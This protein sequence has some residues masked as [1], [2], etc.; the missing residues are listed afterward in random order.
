MNSIKTKKIIVV[1]WQIK[2]NSRIQKIVLVLIKTQNNMNSTKFSPNKS[3][4]GLIN[5]STKVIK[6][7]ITR[8]LVKLELNMMRWLYY[9][10]SKTK[11]IL[12]YFNSI[13][14]LIVIFLQ[15]IYVFFHI[16][17]IWYILTWNKMILQIFIIYCVFSL[18]NIVHIIFI[19]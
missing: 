10:T 15:Q 16:K 8:S 12:N 11:N 9:H 2:N 5:T 14:K 7:I 18:P 4:T 3:F 6:A 19:G 13:L 17:S 1:L